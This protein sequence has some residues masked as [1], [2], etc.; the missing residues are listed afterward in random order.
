MTIHMCMIT[1]EAMD[2]RWCRLL[3]SCASRGIGCNLMWYINVCT[4][5]SLSPPSL[6]THCSVSMC[7]LCSCYCCCIN[8]NIWTVTELQRYNILNI[9]RTISLNIYMRYTVYHL[10]QHSFYTTFCNC[11]NIYVI[12]DHCDGPAVSECKVTNIVGPLLLEVLTCFSF[13][14]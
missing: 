11:C 14:F 4:P 2:W 13:V 8:Y 12:C 9:C 1:N 3:S 5:L 7:P 10:C 6:G